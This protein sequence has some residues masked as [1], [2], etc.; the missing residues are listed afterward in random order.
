M[1]LDNKEKTKIYKTISKQN[2]EK[3]ISTGDVN[4]RCDVQFHCQGGHN[5]P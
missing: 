3:T 1:L 4:P 5:N 2:Y